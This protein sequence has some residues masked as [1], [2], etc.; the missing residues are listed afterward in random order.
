[1]KYCKPELSFFIFTSYERSECFIFGVKRK[2]LHNEVA[3]SEKD[4]FLWSTPVG[5][6]SILRHCR[7][8]WSTANAVWSKA[9]SGF[10]FFC[11]EIKAKKMAEREGFD[12]EGE[13]R[14]R[15][16]A[17]RRQPRTQK[18]SLFI[19][20]EFHE[21]KNAV[22]KII[23]PRRLSFRV[24]FISITRIWEQLLFNIRW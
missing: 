19:Q 17:Q 14:R 18:S 20:K 16:W 10:I 11:L 12:K 21:I 15:A 2:M 1:M 9:F 5:V 6:W 23:F 7:K 13:A 4:S 3:S 22:K 24:D 8:I